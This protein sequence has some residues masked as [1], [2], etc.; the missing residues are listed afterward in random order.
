MNEG[1]QS[2][3]QTLV[4]ATSNLGKIAEFNTFFSSLSL[5]IVKQPQGLEINETGKTF[6]QNARLK[7]LA[8][9]KLTGQLSLADDSGL[10]IHALG[11]APGI[12][13]ARYANTDQERINRVLQELVPFRN[14]EAA[15]CSALCLVSPQGD[16]L[17]EVEGICEGV[18]VDEPRGNNGFGYDPIFEVKSIGLTFAEMDKEQKSSLG[19]RGKAVKKLLPKMSELLQAYS[20]GKYN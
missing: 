18:I 12:Y 8:V 19:H 3:W 15:F 14:R 6:A 1:N 7:A 16:V 20:M 9:A 13:S 4:I 2:S 17:V 11:G 5:R 10:S